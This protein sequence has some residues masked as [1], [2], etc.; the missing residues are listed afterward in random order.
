[1]MNTSVKELFRGA[2][3]FAE[4]EVTVSGWIR[5]IRVSKNLGFI[6]LND[7]TFFKCVQIVIEDNLDNFE[8]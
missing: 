2:E 3:N 7:G 5:N 8:R 6:E 4:K 1:M